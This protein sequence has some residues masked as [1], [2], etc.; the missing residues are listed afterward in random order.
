MLL[1]LK[2]V[3][4]ANFW[5]V[6]SVY[7]WKGKVVSGKEVTLILK[8]RGAYYKKIESL[9]KK[10]HSYDVPCICQLEVKKADCQFLNWLTK[11]TRII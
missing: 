11:E 2:L 6:D 3:S 5:Q 1:K 10:I 9:I 7:N 4:C 8:T